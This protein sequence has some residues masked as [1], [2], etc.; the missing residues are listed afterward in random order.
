[1]RPYSDEFASKLGYRAFRIEPAA[2]GKRLDAIFCSGKVGSTLLLEWT[3]AGSVDS[4]KQNQLEHYGTLDRRS[5]VDVMAV[6]AGA[7]Q[8]HSVAVI[9]APAAK[10]AFRD[11]IDGRKLPFPLMVF[12][13]TAARFSLKKE[14]NSYSE[15]STEQFFQKG[16]IV[17]HIP[18]HYLPVPL[19]VNADVLRQKLSPYVVVRVLKYIARDAGSLDVA[20]LCNDCIPSWAVIDESKRTELKRAA[21]GILTQLSKTEVG[22]RL[23]LKR[24][25]DSPVN[26]QLASS[27][28]LRR[29]T[30]FIKRGLDSFVAELQGQPP[31]QEL[32]F[33]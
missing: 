12:S 31:Q 20:T 29:N 3:E 18:T 10:G 13:Y 4:R 28:V 25:L 8:V 5:L 30:P 6:P 9:V 33:G 11:F 1:L 16:I 15:P 27:A 23:L 7:A 2:L 24:T 32:T 14:A 26:W 21:S 17:R 22:S 19:D